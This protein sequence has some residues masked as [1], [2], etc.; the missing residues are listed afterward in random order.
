[1][2]FFFSASGSRKASWPFP[3]ASVEQAVF[4]LEFSSV[5]DKSL[6][7]S[8]ATGFVTEI[9]GEPYFVTNFHVVH[10]IFSLKKEA[11]LR[12][13]NKKG[14]VLEIEEIAG[15]SFLYDLALIKVK[16]GYKGPV[17]RLADEIGSDKKPI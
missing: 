6:D 15:L 5:D 11:T 17:L 7:I 4:R 16:E 2:S 10:E 3:T 8:T 12:I 13:K 14:K 1:M 9:E